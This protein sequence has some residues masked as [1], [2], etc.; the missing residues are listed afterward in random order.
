VKS[1][2]AGSEP[3]RSG[4]KR[5]DPDPFGSI[6]SLATLIS[7]RCSRQVQLV[8]LYL[9]YIVVSR[10]ISRELS[11]FFLSPSL[12]LS[13]PYPE[14]TPPMSLPLE[15]FEDVAQFLCKCKKCAPRGGKQLPRSTWY[16]HNPGG[17]RNKAPELSQQEIDYLHISTR[18]TVG[19]SSVRTRLDHHICA[20]Y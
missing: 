11:C 9:E 4:T 6:R 14:S 17:S 12:S 1:R 7:T 18:A 8:F 5:G 13:L 10:N 16:K 3:A 15:A 19:S 20:S 2:S